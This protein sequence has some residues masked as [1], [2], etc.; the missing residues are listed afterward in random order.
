MTAQVSVSATIQPSRAA[1]GVAGDPVLV[2]RNLGRRYGS[3]WAIRGVS[4]ELCAGDVL[5]FI[6]PN[7][8]GSRRF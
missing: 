3:Q 8:G 7:G 6:G 2:T 1:A 4:V 5:G